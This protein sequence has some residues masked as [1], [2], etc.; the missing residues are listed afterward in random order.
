MR[1]VG[2][3]ILSA[4]SSNLTHKNADGME[5]EAFVDVSSCFELFRASGDEPFSC[6]IVSNDGV[7]MISCACVRVSDFQYANMC[8]FSPFQLVN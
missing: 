8:R 4:G 6:L 5:K 7:Y 2:P 3:A 1:Q